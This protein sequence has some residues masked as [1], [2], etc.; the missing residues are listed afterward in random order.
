MF[1]SFINLTK[2]L[3]FLLLPSFYTINWYQT[4]PSRQ[5]YKHANKLFH[6]KKS[7][8]VMQKSDAKSDAKKWFTTRGKFFSPCTKAA[9]KMETIVLD[10]SI[11]MYIYFKIYTW[12]EH[13]I[14]LKYIPSINYVAHIYWKT[15]CVDMFI[16]INIIYI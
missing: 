3:Y 7:G 15:F 2:Y 10:I 5:P 4:Q 13:F 9:N 14:W 1:V 8:K 11:Y 16:Y 6:S 12:S